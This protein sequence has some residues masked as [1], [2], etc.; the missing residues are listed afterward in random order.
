MREAALLT[1]LRRR[2][3]ELKGVFLLVMAS[4]MVLFR[5]QVAHWRSPPSSD[6]N[7]TTAE[8]ATL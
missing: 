7:L 8:P 4:L 6:F 1:P 5:E 2:T 3:D